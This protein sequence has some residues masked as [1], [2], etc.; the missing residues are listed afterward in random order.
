MAQTNTAAAPGT[1]ATQD[2]RSY[3]VIFV[4]SFLVFLVIAL[5]GQLFGCHWRFWLPG[6]VGV[7]S[8]FGGVKAAVYTF[9]S[10]LQ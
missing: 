2:L 4:L 9:M 7:K 3:S 10:Y 8:I 1:T 6:S 5:T